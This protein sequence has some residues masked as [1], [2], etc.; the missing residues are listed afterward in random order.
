VADFDFHIERATW[1]FQQGLPWISSVLEEML[2]QYII[3]QIAL[4]LSQNN[5]NNKNLAPTSHKTQCICI[6]NT[7]W[8]MTSWQI[9]E[10]YFENNKKHI[11]TLCG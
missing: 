3:F 9:I 5:L 11:N 1:K 4:Y 8:L 10:L 7:I 6:T 2:S